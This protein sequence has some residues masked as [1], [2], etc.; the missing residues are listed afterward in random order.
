ML[1]EFQLVLTLIEKMIK[2]VD[3][4]LLNSLAPCEKIC[5]VYSHH[6]SLIGKFL[7]YMISDDR[8]KKSEVGMRK[9]ERKE[10]GRG[11]AEI[12]KETTSMHGAIIDCGSGFQPRFTESGIYL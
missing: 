6:F 4:L 12:D 5:R 1:F 2:Y 8:E 10:V 9:S 3:Y 7:W 11:N